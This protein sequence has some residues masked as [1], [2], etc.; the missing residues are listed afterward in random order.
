[1]GTHQPASVFPFTLQLPVI[2][3]Y[4]YVIVN[5]HKMPSYTIRIVPTFIAGAVFMLV[6]PFLASLGGPTLNFWACFI[7]IALMGISMGINNVSLFQLAAELKANYL[8]GLFLGQ[9]LGAILLNLL[10]VWTLSRWP[11]NETSPNGLFQ[12]TLAFYLIT[13]TFL[14]ACGIAHC[15]QREKIEALR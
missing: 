13:A 9:G 4:V 6:M 12:S 14:A 8:A 7:A 3:T 10:R 1:M 2:V 15:V 5:A 11:V